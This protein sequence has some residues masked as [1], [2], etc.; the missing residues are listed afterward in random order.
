MVAMQPCEIPLQKICFLFTII[1]YISY[2]DRCQLF[3]C[4]IIF[5]EYYTKIAAGDCGVPHFYRIM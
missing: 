1:F 2:I 5:Y 3:F 4:L